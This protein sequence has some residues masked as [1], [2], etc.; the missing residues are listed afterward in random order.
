MKSFSSFTHKFSLI[1]LWVLMGSTGFGVVALGGNF[2]WNLRIWTVSLIVF[3]LLRSI[4]FSAY[5]GSH[6]HVVSCM[7]Y[8]CGY[9]VAALLSGINA[10]DM[11][12]FVQR[13]VLIAVLGMLFIM[14]TG[15]RSN[16]QLVMCINTV[17]YFGAFCAVI[18]V[19]DIYF[20]LYHPDIFALIHQFDAGEQFK[21]NGVG[22]LSRYDLT[23]RARGFF[24]E[25]NEFSQY[26]V[27]PFGY[28]LARVF[29]PLYRKDS[30]YFILVGFFVFLVA[31]IATLSRGGV[32][33]YLVEFIAV[34]MVSK[35]SGVNRSTVMNTKSA[36]SI[37]GFCIVCLIFLFS[38]EDVMAT[39]NIFVERMTT[40]GTSDDWTIG[41][42]LST[43]GIGISQGFL[44][45]PNFFFG[46]G[47]G[48]L[49]QTLVNE[50]TTTNHFVDVFVENGFIGLIFYI[51]II[52]SILIRSHRF[53]KNARILKDKRIFTLFVGAYL[54]FLGHLVAGMTYPTHMLFF[55]W[56]N[57]GLLVAISM[58]RVD[59]SSTANRGVVTQRW[60]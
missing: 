57:A 1:T 38:D 3:I 34:F 45:W 23:I 14:L 46:F 18:G 2:G 4:H 21:I 22:E 41:I 51:M 40:T 42:R 31:Q 20:S 55:F 52:V 25:P 54:T 36:L 53:L 39:A 49:S 12:L 50:A 27:L 8:V 48:N 6:I 58:H 5:K 24:T 43:V 15:I 9:V 28:F 13:I 16:E 32:L 47:A 37:I 30:K 19:M 60:F 17:I 59:S 56:L 35:I 26:L 7:I 29:F 44:S 10:L 33:G 11:T